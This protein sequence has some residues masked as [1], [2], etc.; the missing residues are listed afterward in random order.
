MSHPKVD[1]H[2]PLLYVAGRDPTQAIVL[3]VQMVGHTLETDPVQESGLDRDTAPPHEIDLVTETDLEMTI[4]DG[5]VPL[6]V[7]LE[8]EIDSTLARIILDDDEMIRGA[9]GVIQEEE[10]TL[11]EEIVIIHDEALL[12]FDRADDLLPHLVIWMTALHYQINIRLHPVPLTNTDQHTLHDSDL[13]SMIKVLREIKKLA[14]E[15]LHQTLVAPVGIIV[16][17]Q[18]AMKTEVEH[19]RG[20]PYLGRERRVIHAALT[21]DVIKVVMHEVDGKARVLDLVLEVHLD[22]LC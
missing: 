20:R 10:T 6:G 12:Q 14:I 18:I 13:V 15:N 5:E 7:P 16:P 22:F 4:V 9:G 8:K 1:E 19:G 3:E 17:Y 11:A 21:I 2:H